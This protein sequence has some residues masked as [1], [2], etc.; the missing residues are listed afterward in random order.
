MRRITVAL[1]SLVLLGVGCAAS[2]KERQE[3]SKTEAVAMAATAVQ[4]QKKSQRDPGD[5]IICEDQQ[6]VGSHV[7]KLVCRTAREI[8]RTTRETQDYLQGPKGC[9]NCSNQAAPGGK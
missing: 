6:L 1:G 7:P 9:S 4:Q 8:E 5:Q 3:A 2:S